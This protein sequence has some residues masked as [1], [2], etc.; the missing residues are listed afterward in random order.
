MCKILIHYYAF[1][2][3]IFHAYVLYSNF[4]LTRA[5][6]KKG[7]GVEIYIYIMLSWMSVWLIVIEC[8]CM[9]V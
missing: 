1:E 5:C 9:H 2:L 4:L 8:K 7:H 3:A 6:V